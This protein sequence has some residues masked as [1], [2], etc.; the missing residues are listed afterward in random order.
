MMVRQQSCGNELL[1]HKYFIEITV[2]FSAAS[3][4][5]TE[6]SMMITA[7]LVITGGTSSSAVNVMVQPSQQTPPSA[8]GEYQYYS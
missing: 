1:L 2:Q 6:S 7:E 5:G 8:I 4:T 3:Y